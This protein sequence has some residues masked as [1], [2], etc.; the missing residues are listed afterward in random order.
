MLERFAIAEHM[1]KNWRTQAHSFKRKLVK[2]LT[3]SIVLIVNYRL[4]ALRKFLL[5]NI[6]ELE[7]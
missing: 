6:R 7:L 2:L 1:Q 4:Q 5:A 3:D